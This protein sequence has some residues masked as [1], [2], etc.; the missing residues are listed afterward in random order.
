KVLRN[1]AH[2]ALRRSDRRRWADERNLEVWWVART[3]KIARLVPQGSRV[4]EFGAGRRQLEKLLDPT[5]AYVPS[6]LVE[7]GPGTFVC[8][9]NRR[10][11]PD[12]GPL[13]VDT[14]VFGGV[15]E[16][17]HDLGSLLEWLAGHVSC[18]VAS[19]TCVP[20][21]QSA[22]AAAKDRID[23]L[24]YGYMNGYHEEELLELFRRAGFACVAQDSWTTQSLFR[25]V[26]LRRETASATSPC[27]EIP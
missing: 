6:D 2:R 14:A 22:A 12:L 18:C 23:R 9:L 11:L 13:N 3:E 8:D 17:I 16:Y 26:K 25:F 4:I 10:P 7:R 1:L 5:C 20:P 21:A 24:Y 19:Y 15:L 27:G